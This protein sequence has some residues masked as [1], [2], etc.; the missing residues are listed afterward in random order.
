M[1][2]HGKKR[3]DRRDRG[4][5][6]ARRRALR[7]RRPDAD[8]GP[9]ATRRRSRS[10]TR[11]S[12]RTCAA[13]AS[14][15]AAPTGSARSARWPPASPTRSTTRWSRST[16]SSRMAPAKRAENDTEFWGDYHALAWREVDRIRGWST[17]CAGSAAAARRRR[18]ARRHRPGELA[19]EVVT[20]LHREAELGGSRSGR[21]RRRHAQD[22]GGARPD[23]P[24]GA[25]PGAERDPATPEG[26]EVRCARMPTRAAT[27]S[28]SRS[29]DPGTG[30]PPEHLDQIFDPFF[31]T[32]GPDLGL[33]IRNPTRIRA[34]TASGA[35]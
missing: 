22:R 1:P 15:C 20:L 8:R 16:P 6:P 35:R 27:A 23:A 12:W 28:A 29:R 34:A 21:A 13:R 4:R 31:T 17:R 24:G 30:I 3:T 14:R 11:G 19:D 5:Q 26:G 18:R 9:L 10:R 33:L 32:K 2:L 25:E 7:Q